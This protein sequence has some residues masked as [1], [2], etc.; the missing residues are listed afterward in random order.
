MCSGWFS[1]DSG[2]GEIGE[3]VQG[4]VAKGTENLPGCLSLWRGQS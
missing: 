4:L 2:K 1:G 3:D